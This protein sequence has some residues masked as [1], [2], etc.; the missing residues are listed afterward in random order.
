MNEKELPEKGEML[1]EILTFLRGRASEFD[2]YL[3]N[4]S[5]QGQWIV[6]WDDFGITMDDTFP[7]FAKAFRYF[8]RKYEQCIVDKEVK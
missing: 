3:I 5:R 6:R 1:E 2:L 7:T 4:D 8:I